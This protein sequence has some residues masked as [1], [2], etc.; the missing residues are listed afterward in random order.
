MQRLTRLI[1]LLI[2]FFAALLVVVL[3][4]MLAGRYYYGSLAQSPGHS[5]PAVSTVPRM[6][7]QPAGSS[8]TASVMPTEEPT[9]LEDTTASLGPPET[10]LAYGG[11]EV[12]SSAAPSFCWSS[13]SGGMCA[14]GLPSAPPRNKTLYVPAG[15]KIVFHYE[16]QSP[17][18]KVTAQAA[19]P[20]K[21]KN[22]P[23]RLTQGHSRPLEVHGSG[24]KRTIP[25]ELPPRE[26]LV[27]VYVKA[28][29]G[30]VSYIFRV[31]VE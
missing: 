7:P 27:F 20:N 23:Y 2:A 25:A 5:L 6:H 26:Y 21:D 30:E 24:V 9:T 13:A 12:R 10:T 4:S 29:Q 28:P 15:S 3:G 1:G 16:S 8:T 18:N 31:M 14:D 22:D 17:P 11:R 19:P